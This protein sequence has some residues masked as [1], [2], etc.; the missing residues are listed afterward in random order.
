MC[1]QVVNT[2]EKGQAAWGLCHSD[3]MTDRVKFG[4]KTGQRRFK[5]TA[6]RVTEREKENLRDGIQRRTKG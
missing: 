5:E 4:S 6:C 3:H 2:L 1:F